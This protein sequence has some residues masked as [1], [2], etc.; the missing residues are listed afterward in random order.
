M[1][2]IQ[3][4]LKEVKVLGISINGLDIIPSEVKKNE[5]LEFTQHS[6]VAE[7]RRF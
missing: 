3:Y 2:K 6:S 1:D 7:I 4:K 5:A